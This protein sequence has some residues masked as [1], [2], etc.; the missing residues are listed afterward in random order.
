MGLSVEG[1]LTIC[2]NGF[3]KLNKMASMPIYSK[4]LKK[5]L[6]KNQESFEDESSYKATVNQGLPSFK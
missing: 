3:T 6:L 4:T 1:I 2:S 5:L